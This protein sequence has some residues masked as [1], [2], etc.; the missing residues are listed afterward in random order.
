MLNASRL[1]LMPILLMFAGCAEMNRENQLGIISP[2]SS[3]IQ[4]SRASYKAKFIQTKTITYQSSKRS[5]SIKRTFLGRE[6]MTLTDSGVLFEQLW[7]QCTENGVKSHCPGRGQQI[8]V[9]KTGEFISWKG[10]GRNG[11]TV[12]MSGLGKEKKTKFILKFFE[13]SMQFKGGEFQSGDVV[14][15]L[16]FHS[17]NI[18]FE[19]RCVAK[20]MTIIDGRNALVCTQEGTLSGK[21]SSRIREAIGQKAIGNITGLIAFDTQTG[22]MI[23]WNTNF[24]FKTKTEGG[25]KLSM[26]EVQTVKILSQERTQLHRA[27]TIESRLTKMPPKKAMVASGGSAGIASDISGKITKIMREG[28]RVVIGGKRYFNSGSRTN[29]CIKGTCDQIRSK[30]RVGMYCKG[31]TS[32]RKRG[33]EFKKVECNPVSF[34]AKTKKYTGASTGDIESRLTNLKS[35]YDKGLVSKSEYDAKKAEMLKSF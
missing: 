18:E 6:N 1:A 11:K 27:D 21:L 17:K 2:I 15:K 34:K 30:L 35:L 5:D 13:Q 26:N 8:K 19:Y 32:T 28:R 14:Q 10:H 22:A 24:E 29:I 25:I 4:I 12:D 20:G 3:S 16:S 7:D 31:T 23:Y 33:R 9:S